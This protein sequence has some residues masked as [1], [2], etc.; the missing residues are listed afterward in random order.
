MIKIDLRLSELA[1]DIIIPLILL[2]VY[3]LHD[4]KDNCAT[5]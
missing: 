3:R 5:L 2:N 4:D 1:P